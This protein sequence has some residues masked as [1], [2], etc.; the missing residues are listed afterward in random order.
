MI[1]NKI[2]N[3]IEPVLNN[4]GYELVR[5]KQIDQDVLQIML[6]SEGGIGIDECTKASK[7]ISNILYV[8][9]LSETYGFEVSS[10]GLDRPL[11]KPEH[12]I[13][14]IGSSI[15]L[16]AKEA[17]DGKKKFTGKLVKF[18]DNSITLSYEDKLVVIALEQVQSANLIY[19]NNKKQERKD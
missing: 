4:L 14:F 19:E 17:I 3:L 9:G 2:T 13:K 6:D 1:E 12:F 15:K 7:L 16:T 8:E 5:V 18:E 10:P 11:I